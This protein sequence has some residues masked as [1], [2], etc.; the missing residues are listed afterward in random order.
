MLSSLRTDPTSRRRLLLQAQHRRHSRPE[1]Q[2]PPQTEPSPATSTP[3]WPSKAGPEAEAE[4]DSEVGERSMG[5][6]GDPAAA[7]FAGSDYGERV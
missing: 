5:E 7:A 4:G 2:L 1:S 3:L 6:E